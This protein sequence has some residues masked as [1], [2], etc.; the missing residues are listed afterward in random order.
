MFVMGVNNEKY[1]KDMVVVSNASCTTN[2]LSPIAK[3]LNDKF[4][5]I[6]GL[7]T[8]VHATTATQKLLT[9]LQTKT[10]EVDVQLLLTSSLHQLELQ[11]QLEK[12]S[13]N[14]MVS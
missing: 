9:D 4:G 6:E 11:R 10:G 8:T 2:C 7:M 1:T 12:L 5:I 14:L 3:V 13:L